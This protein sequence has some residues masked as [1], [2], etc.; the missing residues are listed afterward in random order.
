MIN[1]ELSRVN[2]ANSLSLFYRVTFYKVTKTVGEAESDYLLGKSR[3]RPEE[4][5]EQLR[6]SFLIRNFVF[7]FGSVPL[8]RPSSRNKVSTMRDD[9][10]RSGKFATG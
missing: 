10:I 2:R 6:G 7:P 9:K 5:R 4:G 1:S 3:H 8:A